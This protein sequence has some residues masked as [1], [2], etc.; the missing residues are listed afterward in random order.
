MAVLQVKKDCQ[1]TVLAVGNSDDYRECKC[2]GGVKK[3][4]VAS[5]R[6]ELGSKV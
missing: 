1:M 6:I 4:I 5:P 3:M 2:K